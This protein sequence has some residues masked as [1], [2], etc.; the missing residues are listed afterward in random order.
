MRRVSR[1]VVLGCCLLL[2]AG[3]MGGLQIGAPTDVPECASAEGTVG[4]AMVLVAQS[5]PSAQLLPCLRGLPV[6]WIF[7]MLDVQRG[8][9]QVRLSA[10]DRDGDHNVMV[11]LED[12]CDVAGAREVPSAQ[13]GTR[14]YDRITRVDPGYLADRYYVFPG[15]CVTYRFDLRGRAGAAEAETISAALGFLSRSTVAA[16]VSERSHGRLTLD[17]VG[18]DPGGRR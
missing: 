13:P 10:G 2:S 18:H 16:A 12:G 3:C 11:V 1:I 8:R 9:T 7:Q 15:G 6:G 5:V 14:R 17:P 4:D